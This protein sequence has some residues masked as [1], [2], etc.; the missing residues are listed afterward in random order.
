M[1]DIEIKHPIP[2]TRCC[3][4]GCS[5]KG[6]T[7]VDVEG[8]A[9]RFC[10]KHAPEN[11]DIPDVVPTKTIQDVKD[12]ETATLTRRALR[13]SVELLSA[14]EAEE[15]ATAEQCAIVADLLQTLKGDA[16]RLDAKK[17]L[18]TAPMT[19]AMKEIRSWFKPAETAM[20]DLEALLKRKIADFNARQRD[21][22]R[23]ALLQAESALKEGTHSE[24]KAAL[25]S[26]EAAAPVAIQGLQTRI[27]WRYR[28]TNI[29]NLSREYMMPDD[30]KISA[31]VR[32]L[33][34]EATIPGIEVYSEESI[35]SVSK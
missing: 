27:V 12:E 8:D 31:R 18:A 21:A 20:A 19:A 4:V 14:F 3:V 17:K 33:K 24:A 23:I 25:A 35:A 2:Q 5:L 32:S 30:S 6:W 15:I 9:Y 11:L 26:I 29:K 13:R 34:A 28:I 10:K 16:K 1:T 22:Q 7:V